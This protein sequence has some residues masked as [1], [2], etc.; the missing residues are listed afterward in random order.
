MY[1]SI[2]KDDV[3]KGNPFSFI[4]SMVFS[5]SRQLIETKEPDE[6]AITVRVSADIADRLESYS[7]ACRMSRAFLIRELLKISLDELDE[8]VVDEENRQLDEESIWNAIK[9][10]DEK[11][12]EKLSRAREILAQRHK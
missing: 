3:Q 1:Y 2:N 12:K 4:A 8:A 5:R 10:F 7:N 6:K 9:E 11:R